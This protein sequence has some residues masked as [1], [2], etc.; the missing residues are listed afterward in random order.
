MVEKIECKEYPKANNISG[1]WLK[2]TVWN[3]Y[4]I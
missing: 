3:C 4:F 1:K 2:K